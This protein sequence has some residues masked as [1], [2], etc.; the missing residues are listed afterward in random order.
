VSYQSRSTKSATPLACASDAGNM[1]K[2]A[3]LL[4][5][6][7]VDIDER[8]FDGRTSID[9]AARNSHTD[10]VARLLAHSADPNLRD[11]QQI[12]PL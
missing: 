8:D 6:M 12:A 4:V 1:D 7:D 10:I 2:M 3:E 5:S 9:L 11:L